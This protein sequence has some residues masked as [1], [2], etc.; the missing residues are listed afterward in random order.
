[1]KASKF[2]SKNLVQDEAVGCSFKVVRDSVV[3]VCSWQ[4]SNKYSSG[5]TNA[6]NKFL[7][8]ETADL[9]MFA[10]PLKCDRTSELAFLGR[11]YLK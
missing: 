7:K 10:P 4:V 11:F 5:T 6:Y 3:A 1:M 8:T 2:I 9:S